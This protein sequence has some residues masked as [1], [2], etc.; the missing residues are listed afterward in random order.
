MGRRALPDSH[1]L[2]RERSSRGWT[3]TGLSRRSRPR[4][5]K[6][7]IS[8]YERGEKTPGPIQVLGL[9]RGLNLPVEEVLAWFPGAEQP[10][11]RLVGPEVV[12]LD[13]VLLYLECASAM[14]E[15]AALLRAA[16][17]RQLGG[18]A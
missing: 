13:R 16:L 4:V 3:L 6:S 10:T 5:C 1:P 17:Q 15:A 14:P 2:R 9:S 18:A 7:D 11:A 8:S 12:A